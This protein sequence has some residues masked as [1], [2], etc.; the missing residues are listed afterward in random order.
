MNINLGP[1]AIA[2][3]AEVHDLRAECNRPAFDD[4]LVVT[5]ALLQGLDAMV[6]TLRT[7]AKSRKEAA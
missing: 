5:V 2:L 6:D 4:D 7:L 1:R 3:I